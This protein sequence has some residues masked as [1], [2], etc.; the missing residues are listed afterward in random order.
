VWSASTVFVCALTLLGRSEPHFPPVQFVDQVPV[1]ISP[2]AEGYVLAGD[3]RI[4]LVT[5]TSAFLRARW[6]RDRCGAV[7]ALRE[8]AGVLAHEEWHLQHGPDEPGAYDAQLTALL[9]V[10]AD[11]ESALYHGV[12]RAKQ[13][14]I[15]RATRAAAAP[16]WARGAAPDEVDHSPM[17]A[18]PRRGN[19][20]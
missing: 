11:Q 8:I 14:V 13:A 17:A 4:V 16:T 3:G 2:L 12:M 15:H 20:P 1:G 19:G 9:Y 6:A 7:D 5:S 18:P 10:G